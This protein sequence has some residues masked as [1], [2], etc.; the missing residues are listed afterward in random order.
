MGRT[1][2]RAW[3]AGGLG[4]F[5]LLG[6][7]GVAEAEE[8]FKYQYEFGSIQIPRLDADEPKP[9]GGLG[10]ARP[11]FSRPGSHCLEPRTQVRDL[12][13]QRKLHG[14]ASPR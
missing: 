5:L 8:K 10:A 11:G 6:A 2:K 3:L 4:V 7:A 1:A 9:P 13:H 14:P 12:P